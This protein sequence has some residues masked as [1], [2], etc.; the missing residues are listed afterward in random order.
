VREGCGLQNGVDEGEEPGS[1]K[2]SFERANQ[3][4]VIH[5]CHS[6]EVG[7]GFLAVEEHRAIG[8]PTSTPAVIIMDANGREG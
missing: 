8:V 4:F 5:N 3:E 6:F 7:P 2:A 1:Q